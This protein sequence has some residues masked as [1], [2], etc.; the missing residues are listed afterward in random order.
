MI[1]I[2]IS[3]NQ[4]KDTVGSLV[5]FEA[6]RPRKSEYRKFKIQGLGQQDDAL[7]HG[8]RVVVVARKFLAGEARQH[9]DAEDPRWIVAPL[10]RA[11][12]GAFAGGAHHGRTAASVNAE[13]RR[14]ILAH[15]RA[16]PGRRVSIAGG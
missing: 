10:G 7:G 2:D 14:I 5:W 3:H 15:E 8:A 6:G 16:T 13:L 1:C 4:G 9:R 12:G 11:A